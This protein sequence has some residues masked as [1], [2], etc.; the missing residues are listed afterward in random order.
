[1]LSA[2]F[3]EMALRAK[4]GDPTDGYT[5]ACI[6]KLAGPLK[7]VVG[8]FECD[9]LKACLIMTHHVTT[10]SNTFSR[11]I[12]TRIGEILE[13]PA[14]HVLLFCSHNHCVP[15]L[16]KSRSFMWNR[17]AVEEEQSEILAG[18]R[19]Y[20]GEL[21][22]VC[23][24][25]KS[26]LEPVS[27]SWAVGTEGRITYCRKGRRADG[28]SYFMREEDRV[29]IARDYWGDIEKDA[30]VVCFSNRQ[31]QPIGFLVQYAGHP[32]TAYNPETF[33]C[34]G[35]WPQV[36]CD[37]L[38]AR[39]KGVPVGFLQGCSGDINS[40]FMFS[41]DVN[42]SIRLGKFLGGTYVS[43]LRSLKDSR[44]GD[45]AIGQE[46]A[47]VPFAPLPGIGKLQ[48]EIKEMEEFIG[49]ARAGDPEIDACV[50]LNF[51]RALSPAYRGK[52][53]EAVLP[54][55]H[56][57]LKMRQENHRGRLPEY[58]EMPVSVVRLGDVGIVGLPCEPF[59][60][61]G[62]LIKKQ[63]VL[64]L[65]IPCGYS[66]LSYGYIPDGANVGGSDYMSSFYR[67]TRFFP[68]YKKPAGDV[69]ARVAIQQLQKMEK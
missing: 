24:K 46:I 59:M 57:A 35:E 66:N 47:K 13:L 62:R 15:L 58:L 51:P 21:E 12:R 43:A 40:K 14:S 50:G 30:P 17:G 1:M 28:T 65:S 32:V 7:T 26:G 55:N 68:P 29:G 38:S 53:V 31:G 11:L 60:G 23:R 52:L 20:I 19:K 61:V 37:V 48:G 36:A 5:G 10:W 49:R 64:P 41:G 42:A 69:L 34:F 45:M 39:Y 6:E 9:G 16:E 67:Y 44:R 63:S 25:M 22:R 2:A 18:G 33:T 54:W 56:W 27:V 3:G 4:I 8:F